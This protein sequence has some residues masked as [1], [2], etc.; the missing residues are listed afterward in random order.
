MKE[1]MNYYVGDVVEEIQEAEAINATNPDYSA[2]FTITENCGGA[3]TF[4]CC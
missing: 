4:F 2:T 3:W 1:L